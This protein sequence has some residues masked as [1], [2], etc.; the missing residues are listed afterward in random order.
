MVGSFG[1]DTMSMQTLAESLT[2]L[3]DAI[4]NVIASI[5]SCSY[6]TRAFIFGTWFFIQE[7]YAL[8]SILGVSIY[9]YIYMSCSHMACFGF[10]GQFNHLR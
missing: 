9:I 5:N 3:E 1:K 10:E 6:I 2:K 4:F 8:S 7:R